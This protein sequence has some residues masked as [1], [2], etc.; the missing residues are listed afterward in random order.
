MTLSDRDR[1]LA[2]AIIPIV[3]LVA[4]WFLL[5]APKREAAATASKD[6]SEQTQRLD[7]ARAA[8]TAANQAKT[9]FAADYAEI[10]R[11]GKAIPA[12]VDMPSLVVQLDRA[13]AGTGIRFTRIAT[14]ERDP[15]TAA[16]APAPAPTG[17]GQSSTPVQAGGETAQSAPGGAV[18]SANN[19]A[20]Q[21]SQAAT[22]AD[23]SGVASADT[24]TSTSTGGGL[25]IG[26]GAGAPGT[27][28][29]A[30]APA[31]DTVPLEME[32]IGN[33]FNLADFFHDIKRFVHVANSNVVVSGRLVTIDG[34]K[35]SS[36][37][38]LFPRIKAEVTATVYLSPKVQGET[39]GATATGPA[40]AT[41]ATPTPASTTT[42]STSPAPTAAATP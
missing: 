10:V 3:L 16:A 35:Y 6:L 34:V 32:F 2:F 25:P 29:A 19:T 18:E 20:A 4:Y 7:Q 9:N 5:L 30:A 24:Q 12:G 14:G 41:G 31:L 42:P 36:D 37:P 11:L 21:Q 28:T 38:Q 8:A 17:S 23:Q 27:P 40:P 1:K 13:A 26:G 22:A 15:A 39:A 33:F